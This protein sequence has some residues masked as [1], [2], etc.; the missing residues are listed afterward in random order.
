MKVY[1]KKQLFKKELSIEDLSYL[2][3]LLDTNMPIGDCI[4][5]LKNKGNEKIFNKIEQSLIEGMMIEDAIK[6]FLP[7][8]L[9]EYIIPLLKNVSF[10]NALQLA[11][12]FNERHCDSKNKLLSQVAYPCILMFITITVLYLFDLYGMDTIFSLLG[13]F[14]TDISIYSGIRSILRIIINV[15]YY[16][17]LIGVLVVVYFSQPKRLPLLYLFFCKRFPNSLLNVYYSEEFVSL[18]LACVNRGYKSKESLMILK[19][20]KSKPIVSFLAFHLDENLMEGESLKDAI[21]KEY[22]DLSLSRF[23]KIANYTNDFSNVLYNYTVLAREK[24]NK[25]IKKYTLTIQLT[26][27]TFIGI[28]VIFI[29]Q[30]LFLPMQAL[31]SY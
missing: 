6:G 28:I 21:R 4:K 29:Y 10:S 2:S 9:E 20:M 30:I 22:Y 11:L 18:L 17:V 23:I 27:Y 15:F 16:G 26:T 5:L 1:L 3:K 12:Q 19:Q 7:K 25:K 31:G 14:T 8:Q 13:S 24:I